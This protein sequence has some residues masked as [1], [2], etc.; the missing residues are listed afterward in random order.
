MV[1]LGKLKT[2]VALSLEDELA[3][4]LEAAKEERAREV[5]EKIVKIASKLIIL[6]QIS[7]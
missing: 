5:A 7:S 4:E 1:K 3:A 6:S 2:G